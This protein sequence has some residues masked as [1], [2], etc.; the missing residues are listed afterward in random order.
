MTQNELTEEISPYT[1]FNA[2]L[3][4]GPL[5][6]FSPSPQIKRQQLD[7]MKINSIIQ[8]IG[9]KDI[10][11]TLEIFNRIVE[12]INQKIADLD[13]GRLKLSRAVLINLDERIKKKQKDYDEVQ[14][15]LTLLNKA[16]D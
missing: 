10:R 13:T 8:G 14:A 11:N 16:K 1:N 15:K 12:F 2:N 5:P 6:K 4:C 7:E 3:L 9:K